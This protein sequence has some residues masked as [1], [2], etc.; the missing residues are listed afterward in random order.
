MDDDAARLG[1]DLVHWLRRERI[2]VL[3]PTPTLL[4]STGCDQ[5]EAELPAISLLYAGGEALP[6]DIADR[7]SHGRRLVNGYGPTECAVTAMRVDIR[8]GDRISIGRPVPGLNARVLDE[9]LREV[10]EGQWG[11]LCLG[12][13][14]LA[15]GYW[16][17]PELTREK[18]VVHPQLGRIYRTGDLARRDPDGSFICQGRIDSQVKVRGYRVELEEIEA[19]LAVCAGVRSAACRMQEDGGRQMLAAFIVAEQPEMPPS[20]DGLQAVLRD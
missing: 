6:R 12:G 15:R 3:C 2:T 13:I 7:W 17:R 9:S 16:N 20:F 4:R 18:F 1:P 5:P 8:E 10:P 11:E 19:R 14:G